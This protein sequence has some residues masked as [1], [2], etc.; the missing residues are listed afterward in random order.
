MPQPSTQLS[1]A[2][3]EKVYNWILELT[4]M[5]TREH[6]L[7]ELRYLTVCSF[8]FSFINNSTHGRF[9]VSNVDDLSEHIYF[10]YVAP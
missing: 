7:V 9:C 4:N 10:F 6:A 2:E 8:L 1:P 3:R 5:K